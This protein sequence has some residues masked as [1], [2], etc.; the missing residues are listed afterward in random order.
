MDFNPHFASSGP[1]YGHNEFYP[2]LDYL[3]QMIAKFEVFVEDYI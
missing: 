1:G 3:I 2:I